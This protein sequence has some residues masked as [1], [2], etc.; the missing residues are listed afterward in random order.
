MTCLLPPLPPALELVVV[1]TNEK[2]AHESHPFAFVCK[3][4]FVHLSVSLSWPG[5]AGK[6]VVVRNSP[7]T[8]VLHVKHHNLE[9]NLPPVPYEQIIR[10][11]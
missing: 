6:H 3:P 11:L 1:L 2:C 4:A 10:P 9:L 7:H 5:S 8:C